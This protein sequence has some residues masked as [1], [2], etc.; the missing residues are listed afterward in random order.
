MKEPIGLLQETLAGVEL[1]VTNKQKDND[2]LHQKIIGLS[3]LEQEFGA[4]IKATNGRYV[5]EHLKKE[6][7]RIQTELQK[8]HSE[9]NDNLQFIN[10]KQPSIQQYKYAL[11]ALKMVRM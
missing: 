4:T 1:A 10:D 5:A 2:E 3:N 9:M 6:L 11:N 7:A 8:F